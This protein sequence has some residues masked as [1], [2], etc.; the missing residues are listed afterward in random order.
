MHELWPNR[1][2]IWPQYGKLET[3][4]LKF[5]ILSL[6]LN[7]ALVLLLYLLLNL[8]TQTHV[9]CVN[10]TLLQAT[11]HL[12]GYFRSGLIGRVL[13]D[14]S[15]AIAGRRRRVPHVSGRLIAKQTVY[16]VRATELAAKL[17]G[18]IDLTTHLVWIGHLV[19][20]NTSSDVRYRYA[21]YSIYLDL[22]IW[23]ALYDRIAT[24]RLTT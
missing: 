19:G 11:A 5:T 8:R 21:R 16:L 22:H 18:T 2:A 10:V 14:R 15:I 1:S 7:V 24:E 13:A 17:S 9:I 12:T 6:L 23:T 3:I 4:F 20:R